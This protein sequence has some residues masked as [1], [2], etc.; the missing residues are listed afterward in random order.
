ML[1]FAASSDAR[2]WF[3]REG[4]SQSRSSMDTGIVYLGA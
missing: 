1:F 4:E 3:P 2:L